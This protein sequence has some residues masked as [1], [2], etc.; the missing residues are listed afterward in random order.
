MLFRSLGLCTDARPE[1]RVGAIQTL[2]RTLQLYGATLSLDT[3]DEC[4]WKV[5]FPL[6]DSITASIRRSSAVAPSDEVSTT[7]TATAADAPDLQWGESKI[8]AL[9]S[10]GSIFQD[11]LT[12]KIML[13]ESFTRAWEVFVGHIQDSWLHDNRSI[14]APALRCLEKAIKSFS[15]AEQL[16]ARTMEALEI[17][18][19]ACDTMGGAVLEQG[20]SSPGTTVPGSNNTDV[21]P[22]TQESLMAYVDVIRCTRSVGRELRDSEW[23]LERLTRLMVILKGSLIPHWL[24]CPDMKGISRCFDVPQFPGL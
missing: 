22:L 14:T 11:F 20:Q 15:A 21:K 17:A 19:R 1:V 13:L 4:I 2:F 9:Q 6:L 8:L 10:I 7:A 23:P 3:W 24:L 18:W 5:T 16:K 12:T